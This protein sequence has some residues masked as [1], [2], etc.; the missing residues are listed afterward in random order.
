MSNVLPLMLCP[1]AILSFL[2]HNSADYSIFQVLHSEGAM[3]WRMGVSG[4]EISAVI[5]SYLT[6]LFV[7]IFKLLEAE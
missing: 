5:S 4:T 2:L 6:I 7:I 3:A 1:V